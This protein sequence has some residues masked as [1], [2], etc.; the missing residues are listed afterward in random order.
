MVWGEKW[1]AR[2]LCGVND[3]IEEIEIEMK[4]RE[5]GQRLRR[6]IEQV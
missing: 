1:R 2:D 4:K 6:R 3:W 5:T